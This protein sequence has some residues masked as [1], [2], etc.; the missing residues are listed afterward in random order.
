MTLFFLI[1]SLACG[2]FVVG[3]CLGVAIGFKEGAASAQRIADQNKP[4][5][6]RY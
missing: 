1:C 2:M 3:Y 4:F 5:F 6:E